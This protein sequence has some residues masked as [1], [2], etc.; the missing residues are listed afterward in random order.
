LKKFRWQLLLGLAL[1][2]LSAGVYFLHYLI[3]N[4]VHHIFI[5]LLGDI[6]FVF[7]EVLLVTIILDRLLHEQEKQRLRKKLNMIIG[8]FFSEVGYRLLKMLAQYDLKSDQM[9]ECMTISSDWG[10]S[11]FTDLYRKLKDYSCHMDSRQHDLK[12]LRDFL[13]LERVF[14]LNLLQNPNLLEHETFT[15]LLW[16]AFHLTEELA[17]RSDLAQLNPPD[18]DHL[19]GDIKRVYLLLLQHW[20]LYLRHLKTVYPYLYSLAVRSNPVNPNSKVEFA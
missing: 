2:L 11:K 8:S 12:E 3:F 4:D 16:A 6:A 13:V 14:M 7:L 5:Y 17:A 9:Q 10:D 15:D 1:V 19:S 18:Y 20:V